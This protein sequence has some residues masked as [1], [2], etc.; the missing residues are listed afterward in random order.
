MKTILCYG[1]SN[2][3]G[4]NPKTGERLAHD[5]RWPGV[6]KNDLGDGYRVIEEGLN[7]RTTVWDDPFHG[8]YKNGKDYLIP[9]LS[10]HKPLDLVILFLGT[11][12][13]KMRFSLTPS[14]V[15]HGIRVLTDIILKSEAG[16]DGNPPELLLIAPPKVKTA[17]H[18][19]RFS[20]EFEKGEEKSVKLGEY[21]LEVAREYGCEFLDASKVVQVSELDGIH[22]DVDEHIKLGHAITKKIKEIWGPR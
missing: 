1:D 19:T 7:G 2:T 5:K 3:W 9:C 11:N 20:E 12:D 8:G 10:S 14:E 6:L 21:Y 22:L 4:Y 16:L 18:F 13:L 17:R 15:T